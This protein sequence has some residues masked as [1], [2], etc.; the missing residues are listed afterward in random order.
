[1]DSGSL[2]RWSC[3]CLGHCCWWM[4]ETKA[5]FYSNSVSIVYHQQQSLTMETSL[6]R[7]LLLIWLTENSFVLQQQRVVSLQQQ[8]CNNGDS[9]LEGIAVVGWLKPKKSLV[10]YQQRIVYLQQQSCDNGDSTVQGTAV[11]RLLKQKLCSIASV[12][13]MIM[14]TGCRV[15]EH[16][17]ILWCNT[18][19]ELGEKCFWNE[20]KRLSPCSPQAVCVEQT[21]R[22]WPV[23]YTHLTLPTIV[24]V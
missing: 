11:D 19:S 18:V 9:S 14:E 4:T 21:E 15:R 6:S 7:A 17:I 23:S 5:L 3:H 22:Q 2:P 8:S 10:L 13:V 16:G 1:M 12:I 24:A 20:T